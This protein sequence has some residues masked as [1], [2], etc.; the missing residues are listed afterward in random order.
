MGIVSIRVPTR[1][2]ILFNF[3][4]PQR[5]LHLG[6]SLL[7]MKYADFFY[8]FGK[9]SISFEVTFWLWKRASAIICM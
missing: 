2:V 5:A 9:N 8:I 7:Q 3:R 1:Q 6:S 4:S